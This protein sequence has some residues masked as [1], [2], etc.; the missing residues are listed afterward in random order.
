MQDEENVLFYKLT[1]AVSNFGSSLHEKHTAG[2]PMPE[3]RGTED[4]VVNFSIHHQ[5]YLNTSSMNVLYNP[6]YFPNQDTRFNHSS[7]STCHA[8]HPPACT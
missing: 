8:M 4:E 1:V 5:V 6:G 3:K 7:E 2:P